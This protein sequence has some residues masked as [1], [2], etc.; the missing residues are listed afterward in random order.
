[1][2]WIDR[3]IFWLPVLLAGLVLL[4]LLQKKLRKQELA[5]KTVRGA[6]FLI[7]GLDIFLVLFKSGVM[8]WQL[9]RDD[10]GKY[11][12]PGQGTDYFFR[13]VY[14]FLEP[15]L[16]GLVIAVVLTLI[17]F[18]LTKI[19]KRQFVDTADL[20]L[21]FLVSLIGGYPSA[22]I[23]LLLSFVLM[24]FLQLYLLVTKKN[25]SMPVELAPFLLIS[26]IIMIILAHFSL[27]TNI[28]TQLRLI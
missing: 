2:I 4:F 13:T 9:S 14:F 6:I 7:L 25:V 17:V 18:L 21:I 23:I 12:L 1:M 26:G 22:V 3:I 19:S 5:V 28:L 10:F 8:Y 16:F 15:L 27:Y 20:Y 11:L 24:I